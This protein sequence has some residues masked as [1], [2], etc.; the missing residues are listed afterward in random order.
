MRLGHLALSQTVS[1]RSSSSRLAVK[2]LRCPWERCASATAARRLMARAGCGDRQVMIGRL[3]STGSRFL[4]WLRAA[5]PTADGRNEHDSGA[6]RR[7]SARCRTTRSRTACHA[8]DRATARLAS[9]LI[10]LRLHRSLSTPRHQLHWRGDIQIAPKIAHPVFHGRRRWPR[11][12]RCGPR[13]RGAIRPPAAGNRP[14][15]A[16]PAGPNSS[17]CKIIAHA[18]AMPLQRHDRIDQPIG[19]GR[20]AARRRRG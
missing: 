4:G 14:R 17:R 2:W 15:P 13:C 1:S 8:Q 7:P 6:N 12:A 3:S 10:G 11:V 18:S 19:P 9:E 16:P 5:R 20:A